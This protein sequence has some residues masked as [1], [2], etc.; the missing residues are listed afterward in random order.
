MTGGVSSGGRERDAV[1]R[2]PR[3][4]I[5]GRGI[6]HPLEQFVAAGDELLEE[7]GRAGEEVLDDERR[8]RPARPRAAARPTPAGSRGRSALF[9]ATRPS[10]PRA[11]RRVHP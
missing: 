1:E 10:V 7:P 6:P 8:R 2:M 3:P 4:G 5:R 9:H 11:V